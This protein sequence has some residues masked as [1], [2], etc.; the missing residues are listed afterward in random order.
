MSDNKYIGRRTF[1]KATSAAAVIAPTIVPSTVFGANAPSNRFTMGCIGVGSMGTGNMRNFLK[2]DDVQVVAVCDVDRLRRLDAKDI[3][4]T[5]YADKM[6][7]GHYSGC[8]HYNDFR[9][10]LGRKDIDLVSLATPDHWHAILAVAAANAGK[11]IYGEKP[12]ARYISEGRAICDAVHR[13]GVVWQTGSWQRSVEHFR[14]ACELVRNGRIGKLK[15]VHV[16]LPTGSPTGLHPEVPVPAGFDYDF[17]LGPAPWAPYTPQRCHWNFRWIKDYSGGQLTDWAGHHCDIAQWGM[18][19]EYTGPVE[20]E[21]KGVYPEE[22]LWDAVTEYEFTCK[23]KNGIVLKVANNK[24]IPM[25]AKFIGTEGW[26]HVDRR[27]A[28]SEPASLLTSVIGKDDIQLYRS[29]DHYANFIDCVRSRKLTITPVEVAHRSVTIGH[30]GDIA[31]TLGR[32]LAW[33]PDKER[34]VNDSEAD[35]MLFRS[36]RSPWSLS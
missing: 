18:D 20:V 30:L 29:N 12:L 10:L 19:T 32:K 35:R 21:G 7:M 2:R 34:F 31:M 1:L 17:W 5:T 33:N 8:D 11:D 25:G 23:Y 3:V 4:D 14:T 13:N 26:V 16:G 36:Y 28:N 22:G 15:E 24:K 9:D 27:E 6:S